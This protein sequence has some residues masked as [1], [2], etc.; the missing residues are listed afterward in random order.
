MSELELVVTGRGAALDPGVDVRPWLRAPKMRKFMG[1][2]DVLAVAAAGRA[3]EEAGL[4]REL[5]E[6]AGLYLAVGYIPF[7]QEDIDR[8]LE[9]STEGAAFSMPGFAA[10]G[11]QA[12]NPLITFR[13]LPNMPA[14]HVS[15][16]FDLQGP[17]VVGYPGPGQL[18]VALE[19]AAHALRAG[20]VDLALVGGVAHQRNFLVRHHFGRVAPPVAP[21]RLG[22]GAGFLVLERAADAAARGAT[23]RARLLE[24]SLDYAPFHPFEEA[25]APLETFTGPA[26]AL[27]LNGASL[28]VAL[29]GAAP[30]PFEHALRARD[31]LVGRSRW[32]V[33]P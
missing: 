13:V 6:R 24:L 28:P 21:E 7:E 17:Y 12:V 29:A 16:A 25:P 20:D 8:L 33:L 22:D 2:Q 27:E 14:F 3:L 32:E 4:P 31:G 10:R 30:G 11:Y 19:E 23:V 5:G 26:P 1:A 9:G 18:Y 15:A